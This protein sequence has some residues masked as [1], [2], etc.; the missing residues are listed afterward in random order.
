M[1]PIEQE[2]RTKSK[3]KALIFNITLIIIISFPL[4]LNGSIVFLLSVIQGQYCQNKELKKFAINSDSDFM[5]YSYILVIFLLTSCGLGTSVH[6]NSG[7][8]RTDGKV[9]P[10]PPEGPASEVC[11]HQNASNYG[12]SGDDG[13]G[14]CHF[15]ACKDALYQEYE[16]ALEYI[17]FVDSKGGGSVEH[18]DELCE[19]LISEIPNGCL[20]PLAKNYDSDLP[21][22]AIDNGSCVFEACVIENA[23]GYD[24]DH[25]IRRAFEDYLNK[26]QNAQALI[27]SQERCELPETG[28]PTP[29]SQVGCMDSEADN[30][31]E[32][33]ME[34]DG[35]CEFSACLEKGTP[36]YHDDEYRRKAHRKYQAEH[37][38]RE[39]PLHND[40]LR[41]QAE[42]FGGLRGVPR[43]I[44]PDGNGGAYIGG[45][46]SLEDYPHIRNLAHLKSDGQWNEDFKFN[47]RQPIHS[48]NTGVHALALDEGI[49]YVG[50]EFSRIGDGESVRR[51]RIAAIDLYEEKITDFDP[52]ADNRVFT[53]LIKNETLYVGGN[54]G[55]IAGHSR[56]SNFAA[57]N[58]RTGEIKSEYFNVRPS[59]SVHALAIHEKTLYLSGQFRYVYGNGGPRDRLAAVD[60]E[61]KNPT[62]F[63]PAANAWVRDIKVSDHYLFAAGRFTQIAGEEKKYFAVFNL[64]DGKINSEYKVEPDREVMALQYL[65]GVVYLGGSFS[66]VNAEARSRFASYDLQSK[67]LVSNSPDSLANQ[68]HTVNALGLDPV[69]QLLFIGGQF[70]PNSGQGM[71]GISVVPIQ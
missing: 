51:I 57:L 52:G 32:D 11:G 6:E 37:N 53:F 46:F 34:D 55:M 27:A 25:E 13:K 61:T 49:L 47:P 22:E 63:N 7:A 15:F 5:K 8:Q 67:E 45:D 69:N 54:F 24:Q 31:N 18:K 59:S 44:I 70:V 39:V 12:E 68:T 20:E 2:L 50:G 71:R 23:P 4:T 42:R 28:G 33:A 35:S 36:G 58:K 64:S 29:P 19:N 10:I 43:V 9:K 21:D 30:Y 26:H 65:N 56:P 48:S 3:N 62:N 60:L 1:V 17:S 14:W 16:L 40:E 38:D 66:E 41:C